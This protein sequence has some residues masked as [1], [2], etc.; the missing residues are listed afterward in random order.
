MLILEA[1]FFIFSYN[2][3]N[4]VVSNLL[5]PNNLSG[6]LN[7]YPYSIGVA[8]TQISV[9]PFFKRFHAMDEEIL[10]FLELGPIKAA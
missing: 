2:S 3:W 4:G 7:S 1:F 5:Q 9:F 6:T 10:L 8:C